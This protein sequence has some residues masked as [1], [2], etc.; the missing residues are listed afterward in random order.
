MA[1]YQVTWSSDFKSNVTNELLNPENPHEDI[2]LD[3]LCYP[4]VN[5]SIFMFSHQIMAAYQVTWS[6]NIKSN[7]NNKLLKFEN[8]KVVLASDFD[9]TG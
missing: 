8:L 6:S 2:C 9:L 3:C 5:Y 4:N 7:V 1:A